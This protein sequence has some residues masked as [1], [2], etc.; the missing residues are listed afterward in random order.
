MWLTCSGVVPICG[1][2]TLNRGETVLSPAV[3]PCSRMNRWLEV[4][5]VQL[6]RILP[7]LRRN[8]HHHVVLVEL[9]VNDRDFRLA[10]GAVERLIERLRGLAQA[11]GG[12]AVI[13]EQFLRPPFC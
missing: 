9:G 1:F 4:D 6:R 7:V 2:I 13:G 10:E 8:F 12:D 3:L 5:I 11:R